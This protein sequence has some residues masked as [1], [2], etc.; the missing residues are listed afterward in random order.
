MARQSTAASSPLLCS[1]C[2]GS[3]ASRIYVLILPASDCAEILANNSRKPLWGYK[4]L[5]FS[6]LVIGFCRSSCAHH[7]WMTG[8]GSAS[9]RF[10]NHYAADLHSIGDHLERIFIS[11]W[12]L[13]SLYVPMLFATHSSRCL[14]SRLTASRWHLIQPTYLHDTYYIIAHFHYIVAPA[15][16]SA[17]RRDYYWF[18]NDGRKNERFLGKVHFWPTSSA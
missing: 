6:V 5:V 12:A 1:T 2:F 18:R 11:L 9:A 15:Q 8:M 10:P 13:H 17:F 16:S 4:S 7:M 3:R 14:E